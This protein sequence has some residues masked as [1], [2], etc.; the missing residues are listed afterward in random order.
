MVLW[1]RGD[2]DA[3]TRTPRAV[4]LVGARAATTY[5]EHVAIELAADL[6]GRG[7][8]IVSGAAYGIDGAAHRA[9]LT[10]GG[11][12]IALLA[13]GVDRPYPTGHGQLI[14]RIAGDRSRRQRGTVR[15]RADE[16]AFP[17]AQQ[18]H[19]GA[20]GCDGR[21][22]SRMAQ[23]FAQHRRP[24]G[25]ARSSARRRAGA[26]HQRGLGG[27]PS[28]AERVRCALRDERGRG[29]RAARRVAQPL[30]DMSEAAGDERTDDT[31]R[32]RDAMSFRSW[33][34]AGEIARRAG[35][36]ESDVAGILGL[37]SLE[38]QVVRSAEGWR[39]ARSGAP[40]RLMRSRHHPVRRRHRGTVRGGMLSAWS[41]IARPTPM[42]SS[43]RASVGCRPRR[44]APTARTCETSGATVPRCR[45][46]ARWTSKRCASGSGGHSARR[47][48]V[49]ARAPRRRRARLLRLG[50]RGG[51]DRR[52]P[53]PAT[54]RSQAR[55][56]AAARRD[57]RWRAE[58]ARR[59][60]RSGVERAIRCC[61]AITRCSRCSTARR[62]AYPS[63]RA[64][65]TTTST[66]DR[67]TAAGA[68]Q[69]LEGA[70][71]AV[72]GPRP[73]GLEA[74]LTRARPPLVR[75]CGAT[76]ASGPRAVFLGA[77]G[78]SDR[79]ARG[80]R[81]RRPRAAAPVRRTR[82]V[83]PHALRHSA[84]TH[85]LDG[86]ADLRAVQEML[87]HASLGTTQIYTHVSSER[88]AATYRLAHPAPE[89]SDL[90]APAHQSQQGSSTARGTPSSSSIGLMYSPSSRTPEMQLARRRV[91]AD[92]ERRHGLDLRMTAC[93]GGARCRPARAS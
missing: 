44:C 93:P 71:R 81:R 75:T 78:R 83:G 30:F 43:S 87:G 92:G 77:A 50:G 9:A 70:R 48:A 33:R 88:L 53:E 80:V 68:R 79:A 39:R 64:R 21:R 91:P 65:S 31:T 28:A 32:V 29:A 82:R 89:R 38:G 49:D 24:R 37:L 72:R 67:G 86:G 60:R 52:G 54:G 34:P 7:V 6:A 1:V 2:L 19:R 46:R 20:L 56:H 62:S 4:A 35:L 15:H 13:G 76:R 85:L 74:Y 45:A 3:L 5:G 25:D 17:G 41:S 90:P 58:H 51:S 8:S 11:T 55:T 73:P 40:A 12:T 66:C 42:R 36:A 57:G 16:V 61:C 23:R 63:S 26:R 18:T 84:A 59:S 10:A 22:R 69:G 14:D 47:R 27:L